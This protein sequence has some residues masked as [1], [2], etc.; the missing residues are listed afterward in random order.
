LATAAIPAAAGRVM[1]QERKI[2]ET[3]FQRTSPGLFFRPAPMMAP[4]ET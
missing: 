1:I 4:V 3:F 2:S